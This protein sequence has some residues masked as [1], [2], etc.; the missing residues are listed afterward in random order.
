MPISGLNHQESSHT[1]PPGLHFTSRSIPS[2]APSL[3][4]FVDDPITALTISPPF[5]HIIGQ[6]TVSPNKLHIQI[7]PI[8]KIYTNAISCSPYASTVATNTS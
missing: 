8:S 6:P 4:S 1:K 7:K 3:A 5:R 2:H